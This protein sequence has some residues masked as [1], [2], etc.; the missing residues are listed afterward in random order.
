MIHQEVIVSKKTICFED[1]PIIWFQGN[2]NGT[3]FITKNKII[4]KESK[5]IDCNGDIERYITV[6]RA[7]RAIVRERRLNTIAVSVIDNTKS[8]IKVHSFN[9]IENLN[10][11]HFQISER[12]HNVKVKS[13]WLQNHKYSYSDMIDTQESSIEHQVDKTFMKIKNNWIAIK[14]SI[15]SVVAGII[16]IFFIITLFKILSC[17]R[18]SKRSNFIGRDIL[19]PSDEAEENLRKFKEEDLDSVTMEILKNSIIEKRR[20]L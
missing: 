19:P 13:L 16:V 7:K 3:G 10:F 9:N 11:K 17:C 20:R 15:T 2:K 12:D 18:V 1:I 8:K 14:T 6:E 4:I 5:R